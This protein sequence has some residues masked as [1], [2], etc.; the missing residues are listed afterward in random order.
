M[1]KEERVWDFGEVAGVL[2][3]GKSAECFSIPASKG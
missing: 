3:V 1:A 2:F